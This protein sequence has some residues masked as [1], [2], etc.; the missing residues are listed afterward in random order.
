MSS[1]RGSLRVCQRYLRAIAL[2]TT[3]RYARPLSRDSSSDPSSYRE[4]YSAGLRRGRP[5]HLVDVSRLAWAPATIMSRGR[6][7]LWTEESRGAKPSQGNQ[8]QLRA[9]KLIIP[10]AEIVP[11]LFS[12]SLRRVRSAFFTKGLRGDRPP[13]FSQHVSRI[14]G[15]SIPPAIRRR[16]PPPPL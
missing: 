14:P 1:L 7:C 2:Q 5:S 8:F 15:S 12:E 3:A 4:S 11:A 16:T 9:L 10:P 6:R 13:L